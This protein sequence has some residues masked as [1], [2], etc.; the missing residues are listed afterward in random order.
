MG[1][2][3]NR[4]WMPCVPLLPVLVLVLLLL[5]AFIFALP[6]LCPNPPPTS[7]V[8]GVKWTKHSTGNMVPISLL[9]IWGLQ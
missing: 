3:D 6:F 9:G 7:F 5:F 1:L 2:G 8:L 4:L